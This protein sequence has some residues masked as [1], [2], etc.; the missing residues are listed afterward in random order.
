MQDIEE[1]YSKYSRIVYK[2]VFCLTKNEEIS[3]DI[4][5]RNFFSG[6]R[7]YRKI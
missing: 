6:C 7:K 2:Y 3:E 1:I 4:V 5:R